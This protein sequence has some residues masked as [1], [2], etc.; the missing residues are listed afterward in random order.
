MEAL[1]IAKY[2]TIGNVVDCVYL[3]L[4]RTVVVNASI[5]LRYIKFYTLDFV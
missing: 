3:N 4:F 1:K 2:S 5:S